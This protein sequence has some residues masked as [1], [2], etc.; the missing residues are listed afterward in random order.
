MRLKVTTLLL[1]A[2]FFIGLGTTTLSAADAKCGSGMKEVSASKC[3]DS[4]KSCCEGNKSASK[5]CGGDKSTHKCGDSK[6]MMPK[7]SG[8]CGTGKCK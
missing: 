4:K 1:A 3:C 5:C 2:A 6:K 7:A 8:K